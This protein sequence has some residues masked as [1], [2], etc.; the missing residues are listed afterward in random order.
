MI[1]IKKMKFP[2]ANFPGADLRINPNTEYTF[3]CHLCNAKNYIPFGQVLDSNNQHIANAALGI[4]TAIK[5][6]FIDNPQ[7][8]LGNQLDV[9]PCQC[10]AIYLVQ[11]QIEENSWDAYRVEIL[12][13]L[14]IV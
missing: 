3:Q 12:G 8:T 1:Q 5:E 10:G 13:V 14:Q 2:S 7:L 4:N 6:F 9:S 11:S